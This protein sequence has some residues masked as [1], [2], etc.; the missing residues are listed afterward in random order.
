MRQAAL[1]LDHLKVDSGII[2]IFFFKDTM[3]NT[4]SETRVW[5]Q[6][7]VAIINYNGLGV[8]EDTIRSVKQSG[9]GGAVEILLVDDRSTDGSPGFVR[10]TFPDVKVFIQPE[11]RGLNA[12][13]NR[14]MAEATHDFVLLSDNDMTQAPDLIE[15]LT[16]ALLDDPGAGI[17]TPLILDHERHDQ[18][19]SDDV[20]MHYL[21]YGIIPLRHKKLSE[22]G[23]DWSTRRMV[24]GS[25]GM[26]MVRKSVVAPLEGFDENYRFGYDEGE[27]ALRATATGIG[28]LYVPKARIYHIEASAG[29]KK[30]R[31][32]HAIANRWR[33]MLTT[34]DAAT[35]VLITPAAIMFELAQMA[36]LIMKGAP[37]EWFIAAG[38]IWRGRTDILARRRK[39]IASKSVPDSALLTAGEIFVF[40]SRM[41]G[42]AVMAVKRVVEIF[43]N[44]Y[45][46]LVRPLLG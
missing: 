3:S 14:A 1:K 10:E 37:D 29:R 35:L 42:A 2:T 46:R 6:V 43:F 28:V 12:A 20:R 23:F 32:R 4:R 27:Y 45:W 18:I 26:L 39:F 24:V 19:Y 31:L 38:W 13:R 41:G 16:A 17:S 21:C 36:F 44:T 9:Y 7:T 33:L 5:P 34:Y 30:E 40:P 15:R 11:N 8:V 22:D 25:G